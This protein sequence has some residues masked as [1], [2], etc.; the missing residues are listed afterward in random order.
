MKLTIHVFYP[1]LQKEIQ[2]IE[3]DVNETSTTLYYLMKEITDKMADQS[4]E[5]IMLVRDGNAINGNRD[6]TIDKLLIG[7]NDAP[8]IAYT[9][10][11]DSLLGGKRNKKSKRQRNSKKNRNSRRV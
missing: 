1:D 10:K 4:Y 9:K 7:N 3:L 2:K 11:K 6:L 8:I 5:A